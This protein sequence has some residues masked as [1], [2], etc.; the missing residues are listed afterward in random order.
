MPLKFHVLL[1]FVWASGVSAGA[2]A[3]SIDNPAATNRDLFDPSQ[4]IEYQEFK[5]RKEVEDN[6]AKLRYKILDIEGVDYVLL[7]SDKGTIAVP[8]APG[9]SSALLAE[10]R[11]ML[12]ATIAEDHAVLTKD[13]ADIGKHIEA[14]SGIILATIETSCNKAEI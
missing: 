8:V 2:Q 14:Y 1:W 11:C 3:Q 4:Y 5:A 12:A 6:L 10:A 9:L 13:E 7:Q